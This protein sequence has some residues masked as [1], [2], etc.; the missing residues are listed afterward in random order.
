MYVF[1]GGVFPYDSCKTTTALA[2][3][4]GALNL[5]VKVCPFKPRAGHNLFFQYD[6]ALECIKT[7]AL[8]CEDIIKLKKASKIEEDPEVL[9]PVDLALAPPNV[10]Y[11]LREE[12]YEQLYLFEDDLFH[13]FT[14]GRITFMAREGKTNLILLNEQ[15]LKKGHTLYIEKLLE[16][17]Q[18][19]A[20][21]LV[22]VPNEQTLAKLNG[23]L[24]DDAITTCWH[25]ITRKHKNIIVESFNDAVAPFREV[26]ELDVYLLS[27][28]GR[29]LVC[30]PER[31]KTALMATTTVRSERL[32]VRTKNILGLL[33]IKKIF[34]IPF[35][36]NEEVKNPDKLAKA[37]EEVINYVYKEE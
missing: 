36:K 27:A 15:L 9:N 26:Y 18:K 4:H 28:P 10:E 8:F 1:V 6:A 20:S 7:G 29:V 25:Y 23:E 22:Y 16:A 19:S 37:Y 35:L 13:R 2:L 34:R 11:Y 14:V 30:D 32:S 12:L 31:F 21:E 3:I 5:G 24:A 33:K 17:A